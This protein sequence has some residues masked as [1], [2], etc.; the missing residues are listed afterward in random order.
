[1]REMLKRVVERVRSVIRREGKS[2]TA[3]APSAAPSSAPSSVGVRDTGDPRT[4]LEERTVEQL[5]NRASELEIEGRS[6]MKKN[7]LVEA[8]RKRNG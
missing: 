1:M 8:I 6:S 5:R 4:P 2:A 7:E 3:A